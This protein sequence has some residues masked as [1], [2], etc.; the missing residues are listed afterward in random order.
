MVIATL[1][2]HNSCIT[3]RLV[4]PYKQMISRGQNL[5]L[6]YPF[7]VCYTII[8]L[9]LLLCFIP[10]IIRKDVRLKP[11]IMARF[12]RNLF[13]LRQCKCLFVSVLLVC[14]VMVLVA[15]KLHPDLV[16]AP[17]YHEVSSSA[18]TSK[19]KS[20]IP[21]SS[22]ETGDV[23]SP[24]GDSDWTDNVQFLPHTDSAVMSTAG[25]QPVKNYDAFA[26]QNLENIVNSGPIY[27]HQKVPNYIPDNPVARGIT[28]HIL[29]LSLV[30]DQSCLFMCS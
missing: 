27:Y 2:A 19:G 18:L 28:S 23:Q 12:I 13:S 25:S 30:W 26:T 17:F 5:A 6:C 10:Q 9:S 3:Y 7:P 20:Q 1:H 11:S 4:Y 8:S 16:K 15:L 14:A 24:N 29:C 21:S 22:K